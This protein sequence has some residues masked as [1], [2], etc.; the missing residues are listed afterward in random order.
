[1]YG[2]VFTQLWNGSMRGRGDLQLVFIFLVCNADR[3]GVCD[4]LPEVIS[5]AIGKDL[6][7]VNRCLTELMASD[8]RSRSRNDDGRRIELLDPGRDWGWRIVNY[9]KYRSIAT[10]DQLRE[11]E[12]FRKRNWRNKVCKCPGHVPDK[13]GHYASAYASESASESE[14]SLGSK[15]QSIQQPDSPIMRAVAKVKACHEAFASVPEAAILNTLRGHPEERWNIAI[16]TMAR[17][18]A[19]ARMTKPIGHLDNY[20]AGKNGEYKPAQPDP[21]TGRRV[22]YD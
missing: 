20:L 15:D 10:K 7:T 17:H 18:Y 16:D 12:A 11:Y 13:P 2:K 4:F 8:P 14:S 22:K 3:D 6:A 1:M 19:G 9:L 5:E 21:K